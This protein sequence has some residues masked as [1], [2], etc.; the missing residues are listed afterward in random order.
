M[1]KPADSPFDAA[2]DPRLLLSERSIRHI[3]SVVTVEEIGQRIR[4]LLDAKLSNNQPDVR[5]IEAG[6]K[7]WL[8]Y[9]IGL[10]V[11][12]QEIVQ[13]RITS[14]GSLAD[15]LADPA[16]KQA[17]RKALDDADKGQAVD[18]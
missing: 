11:Q 13:H 8:S 2:S 15:L 18:V 10:P 7:L 17:L 4:L 12:R 3:A 16:A 1:V 5:A 9:V 6:L 14:G